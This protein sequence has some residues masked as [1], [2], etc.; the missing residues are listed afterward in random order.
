MFSKNDN[1]SEKIVL[2]P[3]NSNFASNL[4]EKE[5]ESKGFATVRSADFK[6]DCSYH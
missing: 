3:K 5:D 4:V 6:A 1:I 2:D